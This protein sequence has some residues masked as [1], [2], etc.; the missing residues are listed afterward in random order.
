MRETRPIIALDFSSFQDV[1]DFLELFPNEEK[2]YVKIGM[3]LYYAVGP[4]I[5]TYVKQLGHSVFL[6]LKL[7]DIPN[8][9]K[10]AMKVLAKLGV[11]MTNVHAAGGVEMMRAAREGLGNGPKL[12]AVTQLTSTS[13]EAMQEDQLIGTSLMESVLHY[14][15]KTSEAGLDGVV[16]SAQEVEL[17]KQSTPYGFTCLTPGI[18]P[19]GV[20]AGDQKRVMTPSEA[21]SI[22]SDYIVVGRP[23]TQAD[24]PV[25]AYRAIKDEWNLA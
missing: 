20:E 12:I 24:N 18:R 3:E 14:A 23:I 6:D 2:L 25:L 1:K 10:S 9:V 15:Q 7:H 5:V 22:G 11:D 21:C 13:Q 8:T 4:D 16:C 19:K 17:I